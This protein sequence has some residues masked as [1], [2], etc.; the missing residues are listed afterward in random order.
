[1]VENIRISSNRNIVSQYMSVL[2]FCGGISTNNKHEKYANWYS[3]L[4]IFVII[5][6]LLGCYVGFLNRPKI[7]DR[8]MSS[9]EILFHIY[10]FS[11]NRIIKVCK[12]DLC[13]FKFRFGGKPSKSVDEEAV[14]LTIKSFQ[15]IRYLF[16]WITLLPVFVLTIIT[17]L[18]PLFIDIN[19]TEKYLFVYQHWFYCT[20][21]GNNNF[22][23]TFL[24]WNV[25]NY[26]TF[27]IVNF[28]ET[29][30]FLIELLSPYSSALFYILAQ[31]YFFSKMK[32][33]NNRIKRWLHDKEPIRSDELIMYKNLTEIVKYHQHL[34]R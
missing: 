33:I 14:L 2:L 32:M 26:G 1:M 6:Q 13:L 25:D 16:L 12:N 10:S 24:C 8:F 17:S 11:L 15:N 9:L 19:F 21:S 7:E 23:L 5:I 34:Y 30:L 3:R 22:F 29:I 27:V 31:I 18:M 28:V 20:D 4:T